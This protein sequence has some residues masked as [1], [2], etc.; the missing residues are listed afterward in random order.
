MSKELVIKAL[1]ES[2]DLNEEQKEI[3]LKA[4]DLTEAEVKNVLLNIVP[5]ETGGLVAI[6]GF[7]Y[8]FLVTIE[9]MIGI[10]EGIWDFVSVELHEDVIVGKDN[11]VRFIQVKSSK[12]PDRNTSQTGIYTRSIKKVED[13]TYRM[14]DSWVDK[15]LLK[16]KYFPA[17]QG[18]Q[19]QFELVTSFV[20]MPSDKANVTKYSRNS[21]FK[22]TISKE[23]DLF[24]RI[25]ENSYLD[26]IE[27]PINY[28]AICGENLQELLSR[29]C[30][31]K[32][33]DLTSINEYVSLLSQKLSNKLEEGIGVE[34]EDIQWLIG[35]LME[36]CRQGVDNSILYMDRDEVEELRQELHDRAIARSS[37]S[38]DKYDTEKVIN[39]VFYRLEKDVEGLSF[40]ENL[41]SELIIYKEHMLDWVKEGGTIRDLINRYVD[42]KKISNKYQEID[43]IEQLEKLSE[44]FRCALMLILINDDLLR[45]SKN[46]SSLLVKEVSKEYLSFLSLSGGDTLDS[47]VE[48]IRQLLV[49]PEKFADI[50]VSSPTT[51]FLHGKFK[52][53]KGKAQEI[54]V[55]EQKPWVSEFPQNDS[56]KDIKFVMN[57][58]PGGKM[59]QMFED[60]FEFNT[61]EGFKDQLKQFWKEVKEN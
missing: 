24:K 11:L 39:K 60:I 45:I 4:Q 40:I 57:F 16:A 54:I 51:I 7:Y 48:K 13:K 32:K 52:G 47:A 37:R 1:S 20:V 42:C 27:Q 56:L 36:K 15:L 6:G 17:E 61:I 30:I 34:L 3:A 49:E 8:Q 10:M 44:L 41:S 23:D 31:R 59:R 29:F 12:E 35:V 26:N 2:K 9:Y 22:T 50:I 46:H 55:A 43:D 19:T 25:N 14:A 18:Y 21:S 38:V 53:H 33:A 5:E 28:K 58:V